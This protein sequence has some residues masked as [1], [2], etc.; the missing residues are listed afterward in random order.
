MRRAA[1]VDANQGEIVDALRVI[2]AT[3]AITSGLGD[4]FPDLVVGYQ[5]ATVLMEVKDGNKA[6][7]ERQLTPDQL[8]WHAAWTG[9]PV[10]VVMDAR[11][12]VTACRAAVGGGAA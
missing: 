1:R 3:V 7:S 8:K 11:G 10:A 5:Q 12:A 2:G 6:P 4:G 9:G